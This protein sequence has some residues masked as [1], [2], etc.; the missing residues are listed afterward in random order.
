M[1][2]AKEF[3]REEDSSL[4]GPGCDGGREV[5]EGHAELQPVKAE[6]GDTLY[7]VPAKELYSGKLSSGNS[8]EKIHSGDYSGKEY[9][10][11]GAIFGGGEG[12][13]GDGGGGEDG[14]G[15]GQH[16]QQLDLKRDS[17]TNIGTYIC[18]GKIGYKTRGRGTLDNLAKPIKSV[19][20]SGSGTISVKRLVDKFE[21]LDVRRKDGKLQMLPK[22]Y[23][24]GDKAL[25][26]PA[27]KQKRFHLQR[28]PGPGPQAGGL[29]T[30]PPPSTPSL[31]S[32]GP[33]RRRQPHL[34][35]TGFKGRG[36]SPLK[37][38]SSRKVPGAGPT[39]SEEASPSL[40]LAGNPVTS[41]EQ[42]P[43]LATEIL[44]GKVKCSDHQ[45]VGG[46]G[47]QNMVD[48]KGSACPPLREEA[49]GEASTPA[50]GTSPSP[51]PSTHTST[52]SISASSH[53][54]VSGKEKEKLERITVITAMDND[55]LLAT[56]SRTH[57]TCTSSITSP[58]SSTC[59]GKITDTTST[60]TKFESIATPTASHTPATTITT[61]TTRSS[62]TPS[63]PLS[64]STTT[65][66]RTTTTT[67]TTKPTTTDTVATPT[68][69]TTGRLETTI[70]KIVPTE[71][72]EVRK[73]STKKI[74]ID[75]ED[76][77][78]TQSEEARNINIVILNQPS[79]EYIPGGQEPGTWLGTPGASRPSSLT[80]TS[81][82]C[83]HAGGTMLTIG[84]SLGEYS[85]AQG[86]P[87][88]G[89]GGGTDYPYQQSIEKAPA[90]LPHCTSSAAVYV[91]F[92][93]K[94]TDYPEITDPYKQTSSRLGLS[95]LDWTHKP[96]STSIQSQGNQ[97]S[98]ILSP[99]LT[100]ITHLTEED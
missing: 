39:L 61:S 91:G 95:A 42:G 75:E 22:D 97:P 3:Y 88:R 90:R 48:Q 84:R 51:G 93:G 96:S 46:L 52:S 79:Q 31:G 1:V 29:S 74:Y 58:A 26:S 37:T 94:T 60:S 10:L 11:R 24:F 19:K 64:R 17:N 57:N 9:E 72:T 8:G 12:G 41:K 23:P 21:M 73:K 86:G 76:R 83:P 34:K 53:R 99:Q 4:K 82:G 85:L 92:G 80:L 35:M 13:G 63:T 44:S 77:T 25:E 49:G 56:Q 87:V 38:L 69:R 27:K 15:G 43:L 7:L 47:Q 98:Q 50:P 70:D 30:S 2:P 28:T 36:C 20:D 66:T 55:T 71:P 100:I 89:R 33:R 14:G 59:T 67:S 16:G 54:K 45:D 81:S 65:D 5:G 78:Y 68:G 32:P 40:T 62:S 18:S 6:G